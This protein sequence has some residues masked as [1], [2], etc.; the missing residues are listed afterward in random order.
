MWLFFHFFFFCLLVCLICLF[1]CVGLFVACKMLCFSLYHRGCT[2]SLLIP[3]VSMRRHCS[4]RCA[5]IVAWSLA[6][7]NLKERALLQTLA[8]AGP[9]IFDGVQCLTEQGWEFRHSNKCLSGGFML[10]WRQDSAS[11]RVGRLIRPTFATCLR[12]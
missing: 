6:W 2:T 4:L 11:H 7:L 8:E 9:R 1:V 5:S 10:L 3:F 12:L